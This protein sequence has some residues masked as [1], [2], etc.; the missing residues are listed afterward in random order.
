KAL[1][2]GLDVL[3]ALADAG[4]EASLLEVAG[5][6]G[7]T[8]TTAHRILGVLESRGFVERASRQSGY[9]LGLRLWQVGSQA[10]GHRRLREVAR[11]FL[12]ALATDTEEHV[13]LAVLDG[14]DAVFVDIIESSKPIRPYAYVGAR[15]PAHCSAT[16]KA[17]LAFQPDAALASLAG[18]G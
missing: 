5:S 18:A 11:P 6:A 10:V 4:R 13:N 2:K 7:L 1:I 3:E 15:V 8:K 12:E 17:L 16:G 9:R 14:H